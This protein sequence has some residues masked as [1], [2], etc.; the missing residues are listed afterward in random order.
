MLSGLRNT[1]PNLPDNES[2]SELEDFVPFG[3][4]REHSCSIIAPYEWRGPM[5]AEYS[6]IAKFAQETMEQVTPFTQG[7]HTSYLYIGGKDPGSPFGPHMEDWGLGSINHNH[8]GASKQ[9]II[10]PSSQVVSL[11]EQLALYC[12]KVHG[13]QFDHPKCHRF[14]RQLWAF[15][16]AQDTFPL[17]ISWIRS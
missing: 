16:F 13:D 14:V 17:R 3:H 12:F 6:Y 10:T 11:L 8:V 7:L 1:I 9:W 2:T 15:P 5:P 4:S